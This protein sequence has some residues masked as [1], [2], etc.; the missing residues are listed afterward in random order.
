VVDPT[1]TRSLSASF[2]TI[3]GP[4]CAGSSEASRTRSRGTGPRSVACSHRVPTG[5]G[6]ARADQIAAGLPRT[7]WQRLPAGTGAK[8]FRYYDWAFIA[9]PLAE[10]TH[11]GHHWMLIRRNRTT[12]ELAFYRCWSPEPVAL[13]HLVTV[14][15]RR[16][17]IEESFQAT[18]PASDWTST[19]TA[20]GGPGTAGP[21]WSSPRTRSSPQRP[22]SAPKALTG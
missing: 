5:L 10:D 17:S 9:L 14:A 12:S 21:P 8:G 3:P 1:R 20:G 18:K 13:H 11:G 7:A 22:Q 15:G 19:S 4:S 6:V 2:V 16:W